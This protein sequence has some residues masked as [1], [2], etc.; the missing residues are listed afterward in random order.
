MVHQELVIVTLSIPSP[1]MCIDIWYSGY[2][3]WTLYYTIILYLW[4]D[5]SFH[6]HVFVI[7]IYTLYCFHFACWLFCVLLTS[8]FLSLSDGF[9]TMDSAV[10]EFI[11]RLALRVASKSECVYVHCKCGHGR[12]GTVIGLLL[13]RLYGIDA[14]R[15]LYLTGLFH[16]QRANRKG[17]SPQT[18]AQCAQV[19]RLA[20]RLCG[21]PM[22][23]N[24]DSEHDWFLQDN[25]SNHHFNQWIF[26]LVMIVFS[27]TIFWVL[28]SGF[29]QLFRKL[30]ISS[31]YK[32]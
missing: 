11:P 8:L 26:Q 29:D 16:G 18:R 27:F 15:A 30:L 10:M 22:E 3:M 1:A 2:K 13:V 28:F 12:T 14:E 21:P 31:I 32:P 20:T 19:K 6:F 25:T 9:I 7:V 23:E 4:H 17:K 5:N 24:S